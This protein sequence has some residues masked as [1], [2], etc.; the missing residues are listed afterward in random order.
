MSIIC[1]GA[2]SDLVAFEGS[3][4]KKQLDDGLL[5]PNLCLFS[6]NA[7][8]NSHYMATPYPN[9]SGGARDNYNYFHSQLR[10]RIECAFG[11]YVQRWGMLRTAIPCNIS[12][13]KTISLVLALAKL[14]NFCIDEAEVVPANLLSQEEQNII[15]NVNGSVPLVV[16]PQIAEIINVNTRTPQDLIGGGDHF[17]DAPIQFK[18]PLQNDA[19]RSRLCNHVESTFITR[20]RRRRP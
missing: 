1:G 2:S 12:V 11:M 14:H 15:A 9:T 6:D 8:I 20:P 4:L 10:I 13:P 5:A 17:D 19:L 16:D 18:R 7:Y 3:D